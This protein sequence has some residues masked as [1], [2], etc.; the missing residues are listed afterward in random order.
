MLQRKKA[1]GYC[2][3]QNSLASPD[4]GE[5]ELQQAKICLKLE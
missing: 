1:S 5:L 2:V 4:F 3:N